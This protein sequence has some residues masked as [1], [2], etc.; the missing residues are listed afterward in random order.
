MPVS[1]GGDAARTGFVL[2]RMVSHS[3]THPCPVRHGLSPIAAVSHMGGK[4]STGRGGVRTGTVL[5]PTAHTTPTALLEFPCMI[6]TVSGRRGIISNRSAQPHVLTPRMG[7]SWAPCEVGVRAHR[8][9]VPT[10]P[11][12]I[13]VSPCRYL[14]RPGHGRGVRL[15]APKLRRTDAGEGSGRM[16]AD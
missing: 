9:S 3:M 1:K 12:G 4:V 5:G 13:G 11:L 6:G 7:P 8:L 15:R 10:T 16:D 14:Q 2:M